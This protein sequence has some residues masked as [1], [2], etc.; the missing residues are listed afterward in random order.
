MLW[1]TSTVS[2]L[3]ELFLAQVFSFRGVLNFEVSESSQFWEANHTP[4]P[5]SGPLS[6]CWTG[7]FQVL[8]QTEPNTYQLDLPPTWKAVAE[9]NVSRLRRYHRR[10]AWMGSEAVVPDPI[11]VSADKP[12]EHE[13]QGI[14]RFR[15]CRG[16]LQCLVRW[17]GKDASGDTWEPVEH[18]ISC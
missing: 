7:L 17:V 15:L 5:S 11:V 14:L 2:V 3:E 9:F 13:V 1:P 16:H 18:L 6:S 12:P 8:W 4:L 10:P